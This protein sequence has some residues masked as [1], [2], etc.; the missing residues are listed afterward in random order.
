MSGQANR[1]GRG[2]WTIMPFVPFMRHVAR[3]PMPWPLW[4]VVLF[5][6]NMTAVVFLPRV[7]AW[8]VLGGLGIGALAQMGLFARVGFVR[9]LGLGHVHWLP[10]VVWLS[11]RLNV[12]TDPA[13]RWWMLSVIAV[14]GVSLAIDTAD[15]VRYLRGERAPTVVLHRSRASRP[16][17]V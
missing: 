12:T 4:V 2:I 1:R 11:G 3:M 15:V 5:A 8:V 13:M 14:C 7:E 6:A 9:L 17:A 16:S 10:M